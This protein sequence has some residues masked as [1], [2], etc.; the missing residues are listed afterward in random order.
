MSLK[1]VAQETLEILE[2]GFYTNP[3][4]Q[5][6]DIGAALSQAKQGTK[7][8]TPE[9][10]ARLMADA[11]EPSPAPPPEV[12]VTDERTQEA[13]RRLVQDEGIAGLVMLNFASARNAGGGFI[14]GAKAQEEDLSRCSGLYPCL[15][16]QP[17]YYSR[18]R[19]QDS[20]LY[21]DHIIYS[22]GVPFF[23]ER[24]RSLLEEPYDAAV[25]TAPAPNAGQY[26]RRSQSL[27]YAPIEEALRRRAGYVLLVA[28]HMGHR[29]L[30]LGAWGCGVFQNKPAVVADAFGAWLESDRFAGAFDSV[31]FAIYDRARVQRTLTTFR[32]RFP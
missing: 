11:P 21:T 17:A 29:D 32:Q 26:L 31:C 25:I 1:G 30:L 20:M 6:R 7:L 12:T 15:L 5:R 3:S 4:S 10:L 19:K 22:P 13:A 14:N 18:N 9:E 28:A 8:F 16:E 23:R 2:Q 24:S 27:D